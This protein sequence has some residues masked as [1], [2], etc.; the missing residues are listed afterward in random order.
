MVSEQAEASYAE[1]PGSGYVS[2]A[3]R[4]NGLNVG[5]F[6]PTMPISLS[7]RSQSLM[8]RPLYRKSNSVR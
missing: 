5:R 1:I 3:R 7:V 8:F 4:D 2:R 6:P